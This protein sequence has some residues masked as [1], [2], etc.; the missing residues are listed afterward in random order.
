MR[1][2]AALPR[3]SRLTRPADFKRTFKEGRRVHQP[4]LSLVF[5]ANNLTHP[6]VGLAIGKRQA[7]L[8]V[9]RNRVKRQVREDFRQRFQELP[10]LDC[11]I[12]LNAVSA[13]HNNLAL[14]V[15]MDR[16]WQKVKDKCS[17]S[18]SR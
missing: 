18:L 10:A 12:Y 11:V 9:E 7:K 6:R 2:A 3:V 17:V 14:R 8:A 5:R 4:P 16:I 1:P 13:D 15:A